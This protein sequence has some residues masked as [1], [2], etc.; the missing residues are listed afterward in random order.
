MELAE[1]AIAQ[2]LEAVSG[3]VTLSCS[4]G[5]AHFLMTDLTSQF[6]QLHP[7]VCIGQ[8]VSNE[9][10]DLIASGIDIAIRGHSYNL[11]DSSLVQSPLAKVVWHLYASPEFI[12]RHGE[13]E[14]PYDLG[15]YDFLT[16]GWRNNTPEQPLEHRNGTKT[17]IKVR[18]KLCSDDMA[19]L[20]HAAI[21]GLGVVALPSYTCVDSVT[22]GQLKRIMPDWLAG[23]ANL[24]MLMP[25]R[26][27][28]PPQIRALADFIRR[29]LPARVELP[30]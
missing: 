16:V 27:G 7:E 17:S 20:R 26:V 30:V 18:A 13:P 12:A 6:L 15:K 9:A 1:A 21:Q 8:Q 24:S 10:V 19:T 2:N 14:S 28:V 25:S 11:P 23:S 22:E 3:K 4:V 29:E 5:V